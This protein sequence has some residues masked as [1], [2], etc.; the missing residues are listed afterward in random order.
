MNI[1]SKNRITK[2]ILGL[3]TAIAIVLV[4]LGA[5]LTSVSAAEDNIDP[6][7]NVFSSQFTTSGPLHDT[8]SGWTGG[9]VTV[10]DKESDDESSDGSE[11]ESDNTDSDSDIGYVGSTKAGAINLKTKF[12]VDDFKADTGL[13]F[14]PKTPFGR[15]TNDNTA[16]NYFPGS[17][18]SALL[19][20]NDTESTA[21]AY[22]SDDI[23]LDANSYY[24]FSAWIKTCDFVQDTGAV[25]KIEGFEDNIGIWNIDNYLPEDL[26]SAEND[27]G[28]RPYTIYVATSQ[29][30]ITSKICLQVG[31]NVNDF[32]YSNPA[33]GY[34]LFDNVSVE[35]ITANTYF[36]ET[37]NVTKTALGDNIFSIAHDF[38]TSYNLLKSDKGDVIGDIKGLGHGWSQVYRDDQGNGKV[39]MYDSSA[40]FNKNTSERIGLTEDPLTPFGNNPEAKA[41]VGDLKIAVLSTKNSNVGLKSD[42][43]TVERNKYYRLSVWANTQNFSDGNASLV[44]SGESNI[45]SDDY[46]LSEV[47]YANIE[48]GTKST[49]YG[50][51]KYSFYLRGSLTKDC[52]VALTLW[53]GY[54]SDCTGTVMF[55]HITLDEI[56]YSDYNIDSTG[57]TKVTFD[58]EPSTTVS[59]GRF[60][61]AENFGKEYPLKPAQWNEVGKVEDGASGMFIT[62]NEFYLN[63]NNFAGSARAYFKG[64]SPLSESTDNLYSSVAYPTALIMAGKNSYFGY[65]SPDISVSSGLAYRIYVTLKTQNVTRGKANL[66]LEVDGNVI[67]SLYGIESSEFTTY[68]FYVNGDKLFEDGTGTDYTAT[69]Y[70]TL[71]RENQKADGTIY[72]LEVGVEEIDSAVFTEKAASYHEDRLNGSN[73]DI[74]SFASFEPIQFNSGDGKAIKD[75]VTW[76]ATKSSDDVVSGIFDP[77]NKEGNK[78]NAYI[79]AEVTKAHNQVENAFKNA[80]VLKVRGASAV[81]KLVVPVKLEKDSYYTISVYMLVMLGE[82]AKSGVNLYLDG[83]SYSSA[84]FTDIKSTTISGPIGY[85]FREFKFY[86]ATEAEISTTYVCVSMGNIDKLSGGTDAELYINKIDVVKLGGEDDTIEE[87]DT[88]RIINNHV[89]SDDSGSDNDNDNTDGDTTVDT[90]KWWLIPSILFGIAIVIAIV[91]VA[92]RNVVEKANRRKRTKVLNSYDRR[93]NPDEEDYDDEQN[94]SSD[95]T[96]NTEDVKAPETVEESPVEAAPESSDE[97]TESVEESATDNASTPNAEGEATD[98]SEQTP[99]A[100]EPKAQAEEPKNE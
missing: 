73:Y 86:I 19:I 28:F 44:I 58:K 52:K 15:N 84:K 27:F 20:N 60:F 57:G 36:F 71:G 11:D 46:K 21:Y 14:Q 32:V 16:D 22:K 12:N 85:E 77:N 56:S 64:N 83:S 24:R 78:G 93:F 41:A 1:M 65:S 18:E 55:D 81:S 4:S 54:K 91:G 29:T 75:T 13:D 88:V 98:G 76:K 10:S 90:E 59:N 42:E 40:S 97:A 99:A 82:N 89:N 95:N 63:K 79:P 31:E 6:V 30:A 80:Y 7:T 45:P 23:T 17:D 5:S 33:R 49:R 74:F 2:T 48:G 94:D 25:F 67:C 100:E 53:L 26:C 37:Q 39:Y 50:W 34:A 62:D 43:F 72:V 68:E 35:R 69:L 87:S 66:W 9:R 8:V 47:E 92:L 61:N 38:D 70:M 3:V 51:K 96:E